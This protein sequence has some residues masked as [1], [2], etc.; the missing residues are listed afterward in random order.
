MMFRIFVSS[1]IFLF[2]ASFATAEVVLELHFDEGEGEEVADS[3]GQGNDGKIMGAKWTDGKFGKALEFDGAG[4]HVEIPDSASLQITDEMTVAS[5]VF[6]HSLGASGNHDAIVAKAN[7]WSFITFRRSN[8]P[9]QFAWWDNLVKNLIPAEPKWIVSDWIPEVKTW[10][11]LAVTMK[12]GE[13]LFFYRDGEAI[14]ESPYPLSIPA[15]A[16]SPIWVGK[17]NGNTENLEGIIDEVTIFNKALSAVEI[18]NL[19][20][21]FSPVQPMEKLPTIWGNLRK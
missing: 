1:L 21:V 9:Y 15:G 6:F 13:N 10:Y 18:E 20:N 19:M 5:W 11:H 12:S 4:T 3:S 16:G 17:G 7:T 14:K 2:L 8:P